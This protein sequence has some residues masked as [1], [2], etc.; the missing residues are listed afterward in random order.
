MIFDIATYIIILYILFI[1]IK[2]L[3]KI[4]FNYRKES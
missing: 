3:K 4:H 2:I 1:K